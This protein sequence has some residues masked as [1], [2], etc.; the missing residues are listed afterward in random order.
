VS[1]NVNRRGFLVGSSAASLCLALPAWAGQAGSAD[2]RLHALLIAQFEAQLARDP[3]QASSLGVDTGERA[4]LRSRFPDW[5]AAGR[6]AAR[7]EIRSDLMALRALGRAG[8]SESGQINYDA[9]DFQLAVN[10]RLA[11]DFPYHTSGFGHRAGPYAVTQLGGFYTA[12]PNFMDTQHPINDRADAEAYLDRLRA[13]AGLID[14]DTEIVRSNAAMGVV[15]PRFILQR[16]IAQLTSLRDGPAREKTLV[17]SL[18]RRASEKGLSG[19]GDQALTIWQAQVVPALA[20]QIDTLT[21]LLARSTQDAGVRRLPDGEAY[22]AATLKLHTTTELGA[23]EI[24]RTGLEQV[25]ELKSR[26][27]ALLQAQNYRQGSVRERLVALGRAPDQV[28]ANDDSGRAALL[29]YLNG[30]VA[31]ITPR[32]PQAFSRMPRAASEIRRVPVEIEAGAPGGSA[33][34]GSLDGSRPGI[35]WIN[36]RDTADWPRYTLPTLAYH[37]AAPGHLFEGALSL[38]NGD[39]PIYRQ[40]ASAT[41]YGEGWGL[42]AEQV[43]DELGMYADDPFGKIGYLSA[44]LF[45]ATRLVVDTG[46]HARGW[47]REAALEFMIENSAESP[48]SAG[49]EID[50]YI[51]YP[52]QATAYKT[53]QI[54]IS[55]LRAEAERHPR[56]DLRRFHDLVLGGGRMPLTLLERRVRSGIAG[57]G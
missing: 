50:R 20:R 52:G 30:R 25:A 33:Q 29:A 38:E 10:D 47:T 39:L 11:H 49:T 26:I 48:R 13:V 19:Y 36:L 27:D 22:Y 34:R 3:T 40:A 56:F 8:L 37:E 21:G 15:A 23:E 28:F 2:A 46:M 6:D 32:L 18:D 16:A 5:S 17:R 55:R 1:H 44:Y 42:Y 9:A 4:A 7:R 35:F 51:V 41:A 45:R 31:A 24:H 12:V 57:W 53:G 54:V 43:A 14:A